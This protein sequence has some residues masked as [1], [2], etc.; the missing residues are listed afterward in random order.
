MSHF[1]ELV[2]T[3]LEAAK[4]IKLDSIVDTARDEQNQRIAA[5]NG[6]RTDA[7]PTNG[8]HFID[9]LNI[10]SLGIKADGSSVDPTEAARAEQN[11][12]IAA[13]NQ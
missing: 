1:A 13:N 10:Q 12:R 8:K 9:A 11:A 3:G 2:K 5:A 7:L 4:A 6:F